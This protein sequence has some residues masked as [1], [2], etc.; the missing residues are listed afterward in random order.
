MPYQ[1]P[2][3]VERGNPQAMAVSVKSAGTEVLKNIKSYL[4]PTW[5]D[6]ACITQLYLM[7]K[8]TVSPLV[9]MP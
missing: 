1:A 4:D 9:Q 3:I 6:V 7:I 5:E 2:A 8:Q